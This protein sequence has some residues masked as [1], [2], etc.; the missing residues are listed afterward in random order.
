MG[1][2]NYTYTTI[3]D[4]LKNVTSAGTALAVSSSSIPCRVVRIKAFPENTNTVVVG[5]STVV[6]TLATRRGLSLSP[7][8]E[9]EFRID[10]VSKLYIDSVVSGEGV[11]YVY[12]N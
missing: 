4:G 8:E 1:D 7:G 10:D 2:T 9:V 6:A 11:S 3:G 12:H 5:A